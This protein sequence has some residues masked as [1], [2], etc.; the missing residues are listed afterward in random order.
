MSLRKSIDHFPNEFLFKKIRKDF[1]QLKNTK[2][3]GKPLV[4]LDSAASTLK[5]KQVVDAIAHYYQ[6]ESSNI[7]RGVHFLSEQ[8]TTRYENVRSKIQAFLHA[9]SPEEIIFTSGTTDSINL[10]AQSYGR[11]FLKK[12]DEIIISEMEHHSNIVPWQMLCEEKGCKLRVIPM[13]GRGELLMDEFKRLFNQKTKLVSIVYVSNTLGTVNPVKE[14]IDEAHKYKAVVLVDGAQVV[15]HKKVDVKELD[16]DF[17]AFSGHKIFG[18][19]GVGILY[20]RKELLSRMPPVQGGGDMID[21]V[22]FE[23]TTYNDLPYKFEAGTPHIAGVIGLG[24]A[25]DYVNSIGFDAIFSHEEDLFHYA[26]E[27]ILKI[28]GIRLIGEA[29]NKTSVLSFVMDGAHASDIGILIDMEGVAIR[30]GHH[31]TQPIM[32]HFGISA[33]ARA[34]FSIYN[35]REDID[36]FIKALRKIKKMV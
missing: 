16:C 31:C 24:A 18:P 8:G 9:S 19:T 5:P 34:S 6:F 13:N 15:A 2:V 26:Q 14:I 23:K 36:V 27:E 10:V 25:I 29:K 11:S 21:T 33:T 12:D 20:G 22:T 35:H 7:H 28:E 3:H 30:T 1:L 32:K 4:Y 17:F